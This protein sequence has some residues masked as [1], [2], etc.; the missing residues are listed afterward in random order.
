MAEFTP[1]RSSWLTGVSYNAATEQMVLSTQAGRL[2]TYERVPPDV[3]EGLL[4]A[5]SPGQYWNQTIRPNYG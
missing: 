5:D 4:E 3:Y 2:Y 1:L